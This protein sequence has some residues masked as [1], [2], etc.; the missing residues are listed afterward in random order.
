MT[1][2][3][4]GDMPLALVN[5][6]SS[7]VAQKYLEKDYLFPNL[8]PSF[9]EKLHPDTLKHLESFV[10]ELLSRATSLESAKRWLTLLDSINTELLKTD[11]LNAVHATKG[12]GVNQSLFTKFEARF[13][14]IMNNTGFTLEEIRNV[15][16]ASV[17]VK[18]LGTCIFLFVASSYYKVI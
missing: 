16:P 15:F 3:P 9:S 13:I 7:T 12:T 10:A 8:K 18:Q 17:L 5:D 11:V 4:I 14:A 1:K 6:I 2:K